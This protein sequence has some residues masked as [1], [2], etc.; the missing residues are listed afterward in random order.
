MVESAAD[1][2]I[3][4]QDNRFVYANPKALAQ[5]GARSVIEIAS[6]QVLDFIAP[7]DR[8]KMKV[9]N[10]ELIEEGGFSGPQGFRRQKIDGTIVEVVAVAAKISW[11]GQPALLGIIRNATRQERIQMTLEAN[12]ER[13]TG[14]LSV[15]A[16]W[17]WETDAE[18]RFTFLSD[19][20]NISA[21]KP[22]HVLGLTRWELAD[23][24]PDSDSRW[25]QHLA[26]LDARQPF[27]DFEY[28]AIGPNGDEIH[29]S[30]SGMPIFDADG[31]FR[32][33]R[34]VARDIT[35]RRKAQLE[36]QHMAL[37]DPLTMLPNRRYFEDTL[38][39][40]CA[41]AERQHTKFAVLFLDI[42]H[43]KDINDVFGHSAGDLLLAEVAKRLRRCVGTNGFV[44][45]FAGD[46]FVII[47][48]ALPDKTAAVLRAEEM[49]DALQQ[50]LD[51]N[52]QKIQ[53]SASIGIALFPE[54]ASDAA[55]L[56]KNADIALYRA[57]A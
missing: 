53:I 48:P 52:D 10:E 4:N 38:R 14:F 39:C 37:H 22:E 18:H 32:G 23:A 13:L 49:C 31:T 12:A 7:D 24:L 15:A 21:F 36:M 46:E 57:K 45:R 5:F 20:P 41:D 27:R 1:G 44:A 11:N 6:Y 50:P 34:G 25:R 8:P 55:N 9:F 30:I 35:E 2:I 42:D 56:L 17:L 47:E 51:I 43:F 19:G 28:G 26:D 40:A 33:Y 54:H 3:V 16:T 29:R